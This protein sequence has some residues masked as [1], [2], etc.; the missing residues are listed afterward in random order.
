MRTPLTRPARAGSICQASRRD[1]GAGASTAVSLLLVRDLAQVATPGGDAAPIRG[2]ALR[3]VEI[4]V[5]AYVLVR[6]GTIEAV[7]RMRDLQPLREEVDE[8]DGRGLSAIPGLVDC[9]THPA[10][11]GDRANEFALRAAGATYEELLAGGGGI[12]STTRAT[13]AAGEASLVEIV[14]R[15]RDAMLAHGTTTWEGKSGYGLDRETELAQLEAVRAADGVPT[16]LGAHA[17]PP[18]HPDADAYVDWAIEHVLPDVAGIAVAADVFV[19]RGTF[20][21]DQARR[22]LLACRAAGLVLRLHGDQ[23]SEIGAVPL[24]I[25]LGARSVDHLEATGP[26]GVAALAA[27]EVVG[28]LLPVAALYLGRPM[29]PARALADAGAAIALATDF[30]PGSA[31]CESLPVVCTL[32]CT[33]LGLTPEEALAACTVNAAHVLGLADRGRIAAGL[34]A[35]LVLLEAP[36]W[37]HLAYH[38]AGDVVHTVVR[39]GRAVHPRA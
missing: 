31:Y 6:D 4:V 27:S 36:D 22:Y 33:Q 17:V 21:V 23:L 11:A 16:W 20:D 26:E 12:L 2:A 38:L 24:A 7:G 15:H 10:F 18:E 28:V 35:D 37:R 29:P 3:A 19:E 25:E 30:N 9:H 13:R 34:R 32:A 8:L 1:P 39:E 5:D 14:A